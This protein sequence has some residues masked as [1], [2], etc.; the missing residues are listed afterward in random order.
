MS[1]TVYIPKQKEMRV[2]IYEE[3][4]ASQYDLVTLKQ[5][6]DKCKGKTCKNNNKSSEIAFAF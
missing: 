4:L 1:T 3:M 6:I 5:V 2:F